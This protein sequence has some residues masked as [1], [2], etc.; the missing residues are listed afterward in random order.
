[1]TEVLLVTLFIIMLLIGAVLVWLLIAYHRLK[2]AYQDLENSVERNSKDIAGLCSAAVKIDSNL[3]SNT[4]FLSEMMEKISE[5]EQQEQHAEYSSPPYHSVIA[6]I[7][8]GATAEQL[9]NECGVSKEE[10]MLLIRLH[11]SKA[12]Q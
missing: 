4:T 8:Q 2:Q 5:F 3:Q 12:G 7:N 6:K 11:S 1:M 10:A 9:V